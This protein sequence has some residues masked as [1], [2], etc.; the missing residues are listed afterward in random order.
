MKQSKDEFYMKQILDYIIDGEIVSTGKIAKEVGISEKSVRNRLNDLDDFLRENEFGT[1]QRKPRVGIWLE[2]TQEQKT[3]LYNSINMKKKDLTEKYNPR[4]RMTETLKIFFH[5][6]PW[7]KITTQ[8]L[9]EQLYLSVPTVLKVL[10]ECENWLDKYNIKLVN[11]RGK[12]YCLKGEESSYRIALKNLIMEKKSIEEIKKNLDYFFTNINVDTMEK[13]I[14]RAENA[15]KNHFTDESFYEILIYCCLA[16]KRKEFGYP[17]VGT[18]DKEELE[19]LQ[20]YNEY[21]FTIAIFKEVED[22]F[23]VR[24]TEEDVLFLSIQIL[25]SKFIGFSEE[26]VTLG[27]VKK[28]DNKLLEF[29]DKLLAVIGNILDMDFS[30]DQKLKESLILH[31]RPTIFRL[32]YG[33][34]EKNDLSEFIKLE[35]KQVFRASWA[36]SI[37]FDEYYNLQ[38]TEDEIGYIVLYIQAAIERR[39]TQYKAVFLT[40]ANMGHAQLIK[41]K[42]GKVIPEITEMSFVSTHDFRLMNYKDAD[43]IISQTKMKEKDKRI[44]VIPNLLSEKGVLNLRNHLK[45]LN[46]KFKETEK[47][48]SPACCL[49]FSPELIFVEDKVNSKEEILKLMSDAMERKG[50]VTE[51]FFSTVME[52][53]S[54]TTTSIGNGVSLPHGSPTEVNES[55]VA[56]AILKE[57]IMWDNELVQII[58]L[59]GF[60]M[61]TKEEIH[62]IQLFYKEYVSLIENEEAL[63]MLKNMKSSIEVYKYLIH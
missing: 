56:I 10:K 61:I 26:N 18:Y 60:K 5:L 28:Y 30:K 49:L 1:I 3:A 54:K 6:W 24:F 40:N 44:V 50:F 2:T 57:P 11:E 42:I 17:L 27:Q 16:Y 4:E 22:E 43:I 36:I 20:K 12:G 51:K 55:K 23:H 9:A 19:L 58:F 14:I 35:Y 32:R 63:F 46:S 29:V 13:C 62:R 7:Q 31:L 38:I 45:K 52:R 39:F 53:E 15:W 34:P 48:F 33:T 41:E 37:L 25:C 59:L 21:E 47:Y 8:K